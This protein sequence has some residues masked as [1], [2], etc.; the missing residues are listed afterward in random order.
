MNAQIDAARRFIQVAGL[1]AMFMPGMAEANETQG[2]TAAEMMSLPE[3]CRAR[4]G[5]DAAL[6]ERWNAQMGVGNFLHVHH[7]CS[8]LNF[9]RRASIAADAKKRRYPL[10]QAINEF[11][12]VL[13]NWPPDFYLYTPAQQ[14][15]AMAQAMLG[16]Q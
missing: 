9:M 5:N 12:Y 13:R 11:D 6:R 1:V 7:Y 2:I 14:Q 16:R 10:Q 15:K 8:G 4:F 3:Y